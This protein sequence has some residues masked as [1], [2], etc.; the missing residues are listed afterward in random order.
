MAFNRAPSSSMLPVCAV[1]GG[2]RCQRRSVVLL[3][4]VEVLPVIVKS[5]QINVRCG[6]RGLK[7]EHLLVG[8][9][10]FSLGV[11]IFFQRD[12]TRKPDGSFI[13]A[14]SRLRSPH[15]R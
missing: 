10:S 13:L 1:R 7:F 3:G 12:A 8:G 11:G 14:G 15:R 6:M 9:D 4:E 5:A 2:I